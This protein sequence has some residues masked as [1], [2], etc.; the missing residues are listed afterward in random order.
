MIFDL[1]AC[2]HKS[3]IGQKCGPLPKPIDLLNAFL[4][5]KSRNSRFRGSVSLVEHPKRLCYRIGQ[6]SD[7][8]E[9]P[10]ELKIPSLTAADCLLIETAALGKACYLVTGD[11]RILDLQHHRYTRIVEPAHLLGLLDR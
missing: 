4:T 1:I 7:L 9:P 10:G 3:G 5:L 2:F 11:R 8:F 6:A